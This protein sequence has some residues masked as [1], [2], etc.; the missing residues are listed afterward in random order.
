MAAGPGALDAAAVRRA[1]RTSDCWNH[2]THYHRHLPRWAPP[3]WGRVI[4]V[5]CGEGL[6]TRRIAPFAR[7][8][9]GIDA[10]ADGIARA[11]DL[12]PH[13]TYIHGD[14]LAADVGGPF[15]LVT[16][17]MV[18]HHVDLDAGL[19]RLRELVAPG[20]T[21]VVV[22]G[23]QPSGPLD[24]WWILL[25][26]IVN[27]PARLI[28]GHWEPGVPLKESH[29]TYGR[30]WRESARILPGVRFRHHLYWRYSLVWRAPADDDPAERES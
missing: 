24:Y 6:L 26:T 18:L 21:L 30:I 5:G 29:E 3:P 23:A 17:F 13:V 14:A 19:R 12:A 15:D 10:D 2:N 11:R 8:V 1:L 16:C 4:D 25:G 9:V 7:E 27:W 22:G 28:R 20:G